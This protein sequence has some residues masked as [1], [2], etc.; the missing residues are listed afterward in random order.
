MDIP[1]VMKHFFDIPDDIDLDNAVL[2]DPSLTESSGSPHLTASDEQILDLEYWHSHPYQYGQLKQRLLP[3]QLPRALSNTSWTDKALLSGCDT[4][5]PHFSMPHLLSQHSSPTKDVIP[6]SCAVQ[7]PSPRSTTEP[8]SDD[9]LPL[10]KHTPRSAIPA[11]PVSPGSTT[12]PELDIPPHEQTPHPPQPVSSGS[13]T[14]HELGV[15]LRQQIPRPAGSPSKPIFKS[16]FATPSPPPPGSFYWKY[17]TP[18]EDA[19]WYD[20]AGQDNTFNVIH[21]WKKELEDLQ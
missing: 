5:A 3:Y 14:E 1:V 18:E 11:R 20:R 4:P 10:H 19:K 16:I 21:R 12:E 8:E 2:S 13:T 15:P 7:Y 9:V 17:V 6:T